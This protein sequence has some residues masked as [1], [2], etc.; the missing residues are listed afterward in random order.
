LSFSKN[1]SKNDTKNTIASGQS[2]V[3]TE[4]LLI[5]E[6]YET[7]SDDDLHTVAATLATDIT[8]LVFGFNSILIIDGKESKPLRLRGN[9][10]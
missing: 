6:Q 7:L 3:G 1:Y 10:N 9:E 2:I 8:N 5:R 4:I